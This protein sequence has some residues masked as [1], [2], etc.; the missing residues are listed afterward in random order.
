MNLLSYE[1]EI[2][3][4][5]NLFVLLRKIIKADFSRMEEYRR[6]VRMIVTIDTGETLEVNI[7]NVKENFERTTKFLEIVKS[8][9][10]SRKN[11]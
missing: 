3:S 8:R 4:Y 9:I 6:H 1:Q 10:N 2:I 11:D 5:L 7:D